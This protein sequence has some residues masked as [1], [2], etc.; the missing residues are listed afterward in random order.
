MI[1][2]RL[3]TLVNTGH[4]SGEQDGFSCPRVVWKYRS[5]A[6]RWRALASEIALNL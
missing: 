1:E 4:M 3:R 6:S 2:G 5:D